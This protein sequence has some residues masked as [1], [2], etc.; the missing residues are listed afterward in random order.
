[1]TTMTTSNMTLFH[2]LSTTLQVLHNYHLLSF[3]NKHL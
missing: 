2:T 3:D 1:M